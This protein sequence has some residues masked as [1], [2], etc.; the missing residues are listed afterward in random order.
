M[1]EPSRGTEES[2]ELELSQV[3]VIE[4]LLAG[5]HSPAIAARSQG[6]APGAHPIHLPKRLKM[7]RCRCGVCRV[8]TEE[9]RWEKVFK[10]KFAD[11]TYYGDRPPRFSSPLSEM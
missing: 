1:T 4:Q 9:A 8:C 10:E 6:T 11:P 2:M 5:S 7:S 3:N